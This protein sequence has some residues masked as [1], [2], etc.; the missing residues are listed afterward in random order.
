MIIALVFGFNRITLALSCIGAIC[1][2][3]LT[4]ALGILTT[5][6]FHIHGAVMSFSG[7]LL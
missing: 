3:A 2:L 6:A 4:A 1:G 5:N 7:L